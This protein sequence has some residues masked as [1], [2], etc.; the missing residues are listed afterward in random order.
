MKQLLL[1][2]LS[3]C[4]WTT[5]SVAQVGEFMIEN[6]DGTSHMPF[7]SAVVAGGTFTPNINNPVPVG[8]N[9][10]AH[11]GRYNRNGGVFYDYCLLTLD[12]NGIGINNYTSGAKQMS[13]KIW[14]DAAPGTRIEITLDNHN[15]ALGGYPTGRHSNY[16]AV[17]T[18]SMAWETLTFTF[19]FRPDGSVSDNI[20]DEMTFAFAQPSNTGNVYYID[21]IAG[22]DVQGAVVTPVIT[23][24]FLWTDFVGAD[25][26]NLVSSNGVLTTD[27]NPNT[28]GP[29]PAATVGKYVRSAA[30][31]D[32]FVLDFNGGVL[33]NLPDYKLNLRKYSVNIYSPAPGTNLE[34]VLQNQGMA[35]N[36]YPTGR[37]ANFTGTTVGTGWEKVV[38][39][40][41]GSP[42]GGVQITEVNQMAVLI[43]SGVAA[44]ATVYLDSLFG[45]TIGP[46]PVLG[47][48]GIHNFDGISHMTFVPGE[49]DGTFT[50]NFNNPSVLA[51]DVSAKVGKYVRNAGAQFDVLTATLDGKMLDVAS[52][53][54]GTK[55]FT[56]NVYTDAA[57]GSTIE[58]TLATATALS[59]P[60]GN[61]PTG[62]HSVFRASTIV[63]NGWQTLTFT[64]FY[65]PNSGASIDGIQK[66][67]IGFKA[68]S[69]TNN[70][71]YFDDFSGADLDPL[72]AIPNRDK[73]W[74]SLGGSSN[75]LYYTGADGSLTQAGNPGVIAFNNQSNVARYVRSGAQY[76]VL[77]FKLNAPP[78]N[79]PSYRSG[80]KEFSINVYSPAVGTRIQFT[81]QNANLA[82]GGYPSGR[83]AEFIGA[84]STVGWEHVNLT[85]NGRP[86]PSITD[87]NI[88]ELAILFNSNTFTP[89][90]I[91][92]D[93]IFGPQFTP[94]AVAASTVQWTGAADQNWSNA[95]NWSSQIPNW[96]PGFTLGAGSVPSATTI[97]TIPTTAQAPL[98]TGTV[99]CSDLNLTGNAA[100]SIATGGIL[101]VSGS[102]TGV[103][104]ASMGGTG[105]V[106][107]NGN[108]RQFF[109]GEINLSNLEI[110]NTSPQGAFMPA[111]STLRIKPTATS[112]SGIFKL[113]GSS[114]FGNYLGGK[115]ILASNAFGTGKLVAI[116]PG[117][118][119][120]GVLT[121][122]RYVSGTGWHFVGSPLQTGATLADWNEAQI[123][124]TP[125]NNANIFQYTENDTTNGTY[126]GHLTEAHGWK[127]P[128]ALSNTVSTGYRIYANNAFV[129]T[130]GI[131]SLT[132]MP[133]RNNFTSFF[134]FTP[135]G[136]YGGGGWN[137]IANPYPCDIDWAV[138]AFDG[139]VGN[140]TQPM[141]KAVNIWNPA[142]NNYGTFTAT[143]SAGGVGVNGATQYIPASQAYFIR[144]TG[145]GSVTY[146]ELHKTANNGSFLRGGEQPNVLRAKVMQGG[147][148][149]ESAILLHDMGQ[150][151]RDVID[152][153]NFGTTSLDIAIRPAAS[154]SLAIAAYP[155][156]TVQ[157]EIPV[158]ITG[159][160]VGAAVLNLSGIESFE[161]GT[162][163]Y[164]RD[165]FLNT[166]TPIT[167]QTTY[168]FSVSSNPATQG[169]RFSIVLSPASVTAVKG[170]S[171]TQLVVAPNPTRDR[172]E[173][174]ASSGTLQAVQILDVVGRTVYTWSGSDA[175]KAIETSSWAPGIYTIMATTSAGKLRARMEKE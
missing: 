95:S 23:D 47:Q 20:I 58:L 65:N 138:T 57:P 33:Q 83:A 75:Y 12:G 5:R 133:N 100:P 48:Y 143:S 10:T 157:T 121:Q 141:S 134:T 168:S 101:N 162:E 50:N 128:S 59:G 132:G 11:V 90:N 62:R 7:S 9:T 3:I 52:Y 130:G 27:V 15:Q 68:N 79:F 78:T 4:L 137:L 39:T 34:F 54:A 49:T 112:G 113:N 102:I 147:V 107:L 92:A 61:Y 53:I 123:R 150:A 56:M 21:D 146:T 70:T 106:N 136:G 149:D 96:Y 153:D 98:I 42:D 38:L 129:S 173:V 103:A 110:N 67:F 124:I 51:P 72:V 2:L 104:T 167:D 151:G 16:Y 45:P 117:A 63:A 172:F 120:D 163:A 46:G 25:A 142:T 165:A 171:A 71:W 144:A 29:V 1:L 139:S 125:K 99:S 111:N 14:T 30:Q 148:T 86:D 127:I 122:E 131:L 115:V 64:Y 82:L 108:T 170:L 126:N 26:A 41:Q 44:P 169:M 93:S 164:L 140:T 13:C 161:P 80:A 116:N 8:I 76:D 43:N 77:R 32:N 135:N 84:T 158:S 87:A 89:I 66:V 166:L 94:I 18:T 22:F 85:Y 91:Y 152:A 118:T 145:G 37:Y 74:S 60:S 17:T 175:V 35:Q 28:T 69:F 114:Y 105:K 6:F 81:L 119:Y 19:A 36:A 40:Y 160:L 155:A 88:N 109:Y 31:Y 159:L 24:E 73:L 55:K 174:A 97:V 156:L 154:L